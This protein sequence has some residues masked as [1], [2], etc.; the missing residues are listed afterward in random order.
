[1]FKRFLYEFIKTEI[2]DIDTLK[3]LFNYSDDY[4]IGQLYE[5]SK[6]RKEL[7]KLIQPFAFKGRSLYKAAYVH[8]SN[9]TNDVPTDINQY[10]TNIINTNTYED[11]IRQS[12]RL[13]NELKDIIPEIEP[14][15]ILIEK[16]PIK[17]EH[18]TYNLNEYRQWNT[19]KKKLEPVDS[20]LL[21]QDSYLM[22][23]RR[24]YLF[25]HPRIYKKM[26]SIVRENKLDKILGRLLI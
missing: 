6:T 9:N 4:F 8:T 20:V 3:V 12:D 15:D 17:S 18:E 22:N 16:P 7:I 2:D 11:L 23:G 13:V 21:S 25:C 5:K 10:F 1:M 24:A 19:K 26:K 14:F